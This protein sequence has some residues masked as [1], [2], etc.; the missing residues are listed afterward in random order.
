MLSNLHLSFYLW[1]SVQAAVYIHMD[2]WQGLHKGYTGERD[3]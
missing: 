2:L 3:S 1:K